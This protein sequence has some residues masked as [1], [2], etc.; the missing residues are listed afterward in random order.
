MVRELAAALDDRADPEAA[1]SMAAYMKNQFPFFGV[2]APQRRAV[3]REVLGD[4]RSPDPDELL[5]FA[6]ACWAADE[7]ELQ[8][9]ACDWLRRHADRLEPRHLDHVGRLVST[10]PWW[11]TVDAL[12]VHVVGPLA[13]GHPELRPTLEQW[14]TSGDLWRERTVILHQLLYRERTDEAFLFEACLAHAPSTEFFHRKA[15]GWALRQHARTAPD[16]VRA[17][18]ADHEEE[19]SGLSKREALKRLG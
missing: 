7:R 8:Y 9:G 5:A 14:L 13:A 15:I 10:K 11:D 16:A 19:L 12:A 4:W 17:F 3:Q 2:K 1:R 6:D 18:V